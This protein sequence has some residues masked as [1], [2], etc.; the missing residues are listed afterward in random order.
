MLIGKRLEILDRGWIELQD[1]MGDD[2]AIVNAARTSYLGES[3]GS[4]RDKKLLFYLMEHH[5]DGPFEMVIAQSEYVG[6]VIAYGY[7]A[8]VF[9]FIAVPFLIGY[10]MKLLCIP[11]PARF[12]FVAHAFVFKNEHN[13]GLV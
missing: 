6:C 8:F 9:P 5:H 11:S 2:L 3:K 12:E 13:S 10:I 1:L 7:P 4:D